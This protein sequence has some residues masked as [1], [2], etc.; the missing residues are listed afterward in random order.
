[1]ISKQV[2][3]RAVVGACKVA[4]ECIY[5]FKVPYDQLPK[6][7]QTSMRCKLKPM[8]LAALTAGLMDVEQ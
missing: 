6:S 4:H 5:T 2:L 1:M 8:V 3:D 7:G